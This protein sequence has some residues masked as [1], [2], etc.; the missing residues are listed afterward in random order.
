MHLKIR[1]AKAGFQPFH[2]FFFFQ[3]CFWTYSLCGNK[4]CML[5][6]S[7]LFLRPPSRSKCERSKEPKHYWRFYGKFYLHHQRSSQAKHLMREGQ[8]SVLWAI[9]SKGQG[10][11]EPKYRY[12]LWFNFELYYHWSSPW[13]PSVRYKV[14][15]AQRFIWCPIQVKG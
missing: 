2:S 14:D 4:G 3:R 1:I 7:F 13:S 11:V 5:I 15:E 8:W 9:Q 10:S 6:A 12:R